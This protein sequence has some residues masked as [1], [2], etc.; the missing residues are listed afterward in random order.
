[1]I[2]LAEWEQELKSWEGAPYASG[3][4][5]KRQG[6]DCLHFVCWHADLIHGYDRTTLP[7]VPTLP[8]DTAI[9]SPELRYKVVRFVRARYP[10]EYI[11]GDPGFYRPGDLTLVKMGN[12]AGHC[13]I[14][15]PQPNTLWHA[16]NDGGQERGRICWTSYG[17]AKNQGIF[18]TMRL[19]ACDVWHS[20]SQH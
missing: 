7:P 2:T 15:G 12:A 6:A 19:K 10:H 20:S 16:I 8:P 9:H 14:A 13:L 1:M 4:A 3:R 5:C 17:W 11:E 18:A